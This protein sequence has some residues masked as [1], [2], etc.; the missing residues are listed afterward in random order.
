MI[1]GV[2]HLGVAVPDLADA[3]DRWERLLGTEA[4]PPE[5]VADQGVRVAFLAAGATHVELLEP[6]DPETPVGRFLARRG[7]GLHHICFAV[8]DLDEA[9]AH[10]ARSGARLIDRSPRR[11]AGGA[12]IA[13]LHP[14]ALGGVLV[15]LRE[16][17]R[18]DPEG[19]EAP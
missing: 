5:A 11:G 1:R 7:P 15:E 8:D 9:L 6:T 3:A 16:S 10:L 13:F 17:R 12:R 14:S 4:S 18:G 2:D 19:G